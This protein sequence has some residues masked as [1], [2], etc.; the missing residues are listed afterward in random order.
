M[1]TPSTGWTCSSCRGQ[2]PPGTRFC[3]WCGAADAR[4]ATST[5]A[6]V[7]LPSGRRSVVAG[8]RDTWARA[9]PRE[10][11]LALGL[12][13]V[14]IVVSVFI[15]LAPIGPDTSPE[16]EDGSIAVTEPAPGS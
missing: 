12:G 4:S 16:P 2:N 7:R 9:T 14:T 10:R 6:A 5:A 11:R 1:T 15:W 8:L 3:A 13:L